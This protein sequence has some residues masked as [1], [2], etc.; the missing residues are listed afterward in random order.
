MS[1]FVPPMV[2]RLASLATHRVA[3]PV[4]AA[5]C[6]L[7]MAF[8]VTGCSGYDDLVEKDQTAAQK[9]GD[10]EAAL[11]RRYDLIPNLVETVKGYA[12]HERASCVAHACGKREYEHVAAEEEAE[13]GRLTSPARRTD[14]RARK[15][16][17]AAPKARRG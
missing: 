14:A 12:A 16:P 10:L 1:L 7:V 9:W 15:M 4:W 5:L 13:I 17:K 6:L 2:S 3:R 11:Q 8:A